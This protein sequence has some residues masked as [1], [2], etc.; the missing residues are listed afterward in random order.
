MLT[1][2]VSLK[3]PT[4]QNVR[5]PDGALW[6]APT[7]LERLRRAS[8]AYWLFCKYRDMILSLEQNYSQL[9]PFYWNWFSSGSHVGG[10]GGLVRLN[11]VLRPV[12]PAVLPT[13][14][15]WGTAS[16][17]DGEGVWLTWSCSVFLWCVRKTTFL[18]ISQPI[19]NAIGTGQLSSTI[20]GRNSMRFETQAGPSCLVPPGS[21]RFKNGV[22]FWILWSFMNSSG[23]VCIDMAR[24]NAISSRHDKEF[25]DFYLTL[26]AAWPEDAKRQG[27][28]LG[29]HVP[30]DPYKNIFITMA[31]I[32]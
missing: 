21:S 9:N 20:L 16:K 32:S 10:S 11:R 24:M 17:Q 4:V 7:W 14:L 31:N 30:G 25:W 1:L 19:K 27:F 28:M 2:T 13:H 3:A 8:S 12:H 15:A 6:M 22:P 18:I 26:I 29:H 23:W 5:G